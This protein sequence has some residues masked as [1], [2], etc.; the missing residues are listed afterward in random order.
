M[1]TQTVDTSILEPGDVVRCVDASVPEYGNTGVVVVPGPRRFSNQTGQRIFVRFDNNPEVLDWPVGSFERTDPPLG[2]E[3]KAGDI[4]RVK[5][6]ESTIYGML[7]RFIAP[8]GRNSNLC[9]I[10]ALTS[11]GGWPAGLSYAMLRHEL[12]LAP[13]P[14]PQQP[15]V[16]S[17][18]TRNS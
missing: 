10:Q 13:S 5:N 17:K 4:V 6:P 9:G 8:R 1:T 7:G 12:E 3:L 2:S 14:A 18:P 16:S 11:V 15:P